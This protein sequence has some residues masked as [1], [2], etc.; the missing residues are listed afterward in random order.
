[1]ETR[2]A[3]TTG[4]P[5]IAFSHNI[6]LCVP[7]AHNGIPLFIPLVKVG[8]CECALVAHH[9]KRILTPE[10]IGGSIDDSEQ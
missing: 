7:L 3:S 9:G 1:M 4:I 8:R 10:T 6:C 2:R 5:D